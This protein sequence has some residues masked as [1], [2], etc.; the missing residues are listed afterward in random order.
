M[1]SAGFDSLSAMVITSICRES[2][3]VGFHLDECRKQKKTEELQQDKK[4]PLKL[5][6]I[7]HAVNPLQKTVIEITHTEQGELVSISTLEQPPKAVIGHQKSTT[8]N[9]PLWIQIMEMFFDAMD[10]EEIP[11]KMSQNMLITKEVIT[12]PTGKPEKH[13]CLFFRASNMMA[14]F[15]DNPRFF[16]LINASSIH[17]AQTLLAQLQ[18]AGVL[19]FN[20]KIKEKGIPINPSKPTT[21]RRVSH[22]VAIDL[23]LLEQ[24]Y[25]LALLNSE[26]VAKMLR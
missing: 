1:D 8:P 4:T 13:T 21:S 12:S 18:Q 14:F 9:K 15:R 17:S 2:E 20:G 23:V 19:A 7:L 5:N 6:D 24:H 22:L 25:G 3:S 16:E 11:E 26:G 10:K